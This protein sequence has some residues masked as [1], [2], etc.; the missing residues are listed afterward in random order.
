LGLVTSLAS[1]GDEGVMPTSSNGSPSALVV[2]GY[3]PKT[4]KSSIPGYFR[5]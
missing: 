2:R 4:Q 3:H 5:P 1:D